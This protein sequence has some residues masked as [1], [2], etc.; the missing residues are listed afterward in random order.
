VLEGDHLKLRRVPY[1]VDRTVAMLE[2]A[3]LPQQ[4]IDGLASVLRGSRP[5]PEK[6]TG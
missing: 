1:D 2:K 6:P 5:N 3:S 4:V